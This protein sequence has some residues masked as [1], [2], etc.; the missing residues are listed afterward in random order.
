M[1]LPDLY[2][3]MRRAV[4]ASVRAR[5]G[6]HEVERLADAQL[7]TELV[8]DPLGVVGRAAEK[9]VGVHECEVADEDRHPVAE[10]AGGA[11]PHFVLVAAGELTVHRVA[12]APGVGSVHDVVVHER[13]RVHELERGGRVDDPRVVELAARADERTR[14]ERGPQP[15]AAR[16]DELAERVEWISERGVDFDPALLLVDE[17]RVDARLDAVGHRVERLGEGRGARRRGGHW[18]EATPPARGGRYR[19]LP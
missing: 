4:S 5:R 18:R 11:A 8:E 16:G 7:D 1:Y 6:A 9:D 19:L 14:A 3:A 12:A 10:P 17:Q 15:L 13:E 2:V